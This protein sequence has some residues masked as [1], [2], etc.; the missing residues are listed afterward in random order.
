[1]L[2]VPGCKNSPSREHSHWMLPPSPDLPAILASFAVPYVGKAHENCKNK[3]VQQ[4]LAVMLVETISQQASSSFCPK[5]SQP[6]L[7][8]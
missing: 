7:P 8:I 2:E 5:D 6:S 3:L 4:S 1:M